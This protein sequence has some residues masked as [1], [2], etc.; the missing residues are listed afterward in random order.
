MPGDGNG[1]LLLHA[2]V[3]SKASK[4]HASP[5]P[6]IKPPATMSKC[7]AANSSLP[8]AREERQKIDMH[9]IGYSYIFC[10]VMLE[11]GGKEGTSK[12][13]IVLVSYLEGNFRLV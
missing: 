3:L 6:L 1:S 11:G 7:R 2:V 8:A 5:R 13:S 12:N 10:R 9:L 4:H